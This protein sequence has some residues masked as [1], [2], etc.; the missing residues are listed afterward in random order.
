MKFAK[1]HK[2]LG[3]SNAEN[4]E[5]AQRELRKSARHAILKVSDARG[6]LPLLRR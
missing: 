2:L 4:A 3:N 1:H 5:E 6:I